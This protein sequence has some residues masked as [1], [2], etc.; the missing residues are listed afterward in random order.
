MFRIEKK[1]DCKEVYLFGKK[2][3]SINKYSNATLLK[4]IDS[5][6]SVIQF[7]FNT[8]DMKKARGTLRDIQLAELKILKEIKR[9]CSQNNITWW[10][11]FGTLLGAARHKGFIP[12]DDD[13]DICMMR[14]DFANFIDIFNKHTSDK[15]LKA[16][17]YTSDSGIYN[18][19]KVSHQEI[20]NLFIDI[21]P[22]DLR[23]Q[24]MDDA[25]KLDF[26]KKLRAQVLKN[27]KLKK[28][29]KTPEE[30]FE[31][32]IQSR[33]ETISN[34]KPNNKIT[35]PTIFYGLEYYHSTHLYN[36]FDYDTIFPLQDIEFEDEM[37][38]SVAKPDLYLTY[39]FGDYMQLPKILHIHT[40]MKKMPIDNIIKI[41][42]Y[43]SE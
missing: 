26:S 27:A 9:V 18:M 5:L 36:A 15:H 38:P 17:L 23:Y 20:P 33:N 39:T 19:I 37:F 42:K 34:L 6:Q 22:V 4:K 31:K 30:F 41:K 13:I 1:S 28:K 11:D 29:S 24:T 43:V 32:I 25:Q 2:L 10:I 14:D 7:T 21:F 12:W 16:G 8:E 40:N 3:F 35:K